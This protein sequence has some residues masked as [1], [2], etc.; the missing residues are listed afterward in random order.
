[1]YLS[2]VARNPNAPLRKTRS[3]RRSLV[4]A[5][6]A[7][8]Q[9]SKSKNSV[10]DYTSD[11][12]SS[13]KYVKKPV[14]SGPSVAEKRRKAREAMMTKKDSNPHLS[15]KS[16]HTEDIVNI[17]PWADDDEKSIS[18]LDGS[19]QLE[20]KGD[21][22]GSFGD[23]FN[24]S[25]N[26][27]FN[28]TPTATIE[29]DL[30]GNASEADDDGTIVIELESD[31][32]VDEK[33]LVSNRVTDKP[34]G[35]ANQPQLERKK[36]NHTVEKDEHSLESKRSRR[37]ATSSV[38]R[39]GGN[40]IMSRKTSQRSLLNNTD[41]TNRA[42][43]LRTSGS[44]TISTRGRRTVGL[45]ESIS[46]I[47]FN[48]LARKDEDSDASDVSEEEDLFKDL[49]KSPKSITSQTPT[50]SSPRG[51][52]KKINGK[53]VRGSSA[54]VQVD[55]EKSICSKASRRSSRVLTRKCRMNLD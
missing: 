31:E 27:S 55:D 2:N 14:R 5:E 18:I 8:V 35:G 42:A 12:M 11:A 6:D 39:R 49:E 53:W 43:S 52:Y 26:M 15:G 1:M 45:N 46:S 51:T 23:S 48:P 50:T 33:S 19:D 34:K 22:S 9:S 32:E 4:S 21:N 36:G 28:W 24:R 17:D 54:S 7:S 16:I 40:H 30:E 3:S 29:W 20:S 38:R 47:G 41:R 13:Y 37:S 25:L 44:R 10:L